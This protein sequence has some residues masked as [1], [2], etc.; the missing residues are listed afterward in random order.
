MRK[1][2]SI[3][4]IAEIKPIDGADLIVAYRI[5]G[6]WVVDKKDYQVD[7]LVVY[8]EPDAW[9]PNSL[10]PFLSKDREPREFNG[11]KGEK[12]RTVRLRGQYS[13]G[14]ILP[15]SVIPESLKQHPSFWDEVDGFD[16]SEVLG[17][18]KWEPPIPACLA[19]KMRGNFPSF[20]PKTDQTRIEN[21]GRSLEPWQKEELQWSIQEKLEGSSMTV[22]VYNDREGVCSRNIDLYETDDNTFWK[23]TKTY[24]ILNRIKSTGRNVAIQGELIGEGIQGNIYNITGHDFYVFDIYLIDEHRYMLPRECQHFV[25]SIGLKIVPTVGII[26]IDDQVDQTTLIAL[27]EGKSALYNTER[28][29]I[30]VKCNYKNET[31]KC[32]SRK[33]LAKQKD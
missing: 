19:G 20:I 26:T 6:W 24:D 8:C 15:F 18:Q 22:Y 33:Y 17:I 25:H 4:K 23:I 3:Q 29:G 5:N 11:V 14:L 10:C 7:D 9:I 28:E 21:L 16:V 32:I 12:L 2:A 27:A 1:M 30:V 31:F 13:Q